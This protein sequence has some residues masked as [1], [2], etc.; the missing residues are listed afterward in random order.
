MIFNIKDFEKIRET[1]KAMLLSFKGFEIWT[2]K[3][4]IKEDGTFK[5]YMQDEFNI[6]LDSLKS[7][8]YTFGELKQICKFRIELNSAFNPTAT[9]LKLKND[10]KKEFRNENKAGYVITF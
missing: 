7:K 9:K 5:K 6:K 4:S 3:S 2:P 8:E 10:W 1:E